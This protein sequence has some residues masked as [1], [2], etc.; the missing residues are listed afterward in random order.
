MV[1]PCIAG[2]A[3]IRSAMDVAPDR[4]MASR[5]ITWTGSAPSASMRLMAEPVIST[6]WSEAGPCCAIAAVPA[7]KPTPLKSIAAATFTLDFLNM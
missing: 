6:R 4:A 3:W 2:S 5:L 7:A 1:K